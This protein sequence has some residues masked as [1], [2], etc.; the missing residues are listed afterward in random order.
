MSSTC[1][2]TQSADEVH[3]HFSVMCKGVF[4]RPIMLPLHNSHES[5]LQDRAALSRRRA[6]L[7][8][9]RKISLLLSRLSLI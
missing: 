9:T 8:C 6:F 7:S 1:P 3:V 2:M 5:M 4:G